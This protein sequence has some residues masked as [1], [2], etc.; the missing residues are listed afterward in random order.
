MPPVRAV[1]FDWG[2]TLMSEDG[3]ED[4][5]MALWPQVRC[6]SGAQEMLSALHPAFPLCIATN[7]AVSRRPMVE[8]A[9]D[10]VGLLPYISEVFCFTEL[11]F[12]KESPDFWHVVADTLRLPPGEIAMLGDS[13]GSDVLAPRAAGLF[14]VWFNEGNS[15]PRP[16]EPVPTVARLA[17][18]V[19]LVR[20]VC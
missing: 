18:F 9:L 19:A 6:I 10:R 20:A 8:R 5:P 13:L 4:L 16:A 7:A 3:P 11:G 15:K 12:K 17:D 14:A 1:C 2:G